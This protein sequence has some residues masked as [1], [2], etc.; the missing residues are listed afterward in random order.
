MKWVDRSIALRPNFENQ[1][2]KAELLAEQGKTSEAEAMR[3][4]MLEVATNAELNRYGYTLMNEGKKA[5]AVKI[6]ELNAKRNPTDPNVH[7]SLGE[8]Y[9]TN[10]QN[11]LAIKSF[12]KSLSM[13]PAEG[14]RANSVRCLKKLGVDTAPYEK[15]AELKK[16]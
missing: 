8:G 5:E 16:M 3:K 2:L 6:F 7:D 10:G 14:V 4:Q 9:M 12:K 11:D 1:S 15:T 13:D